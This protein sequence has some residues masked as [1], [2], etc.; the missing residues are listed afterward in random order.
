MT[1][2]SVETIEIL[3]D[4]IEI[5]NDRIEAYRLALKDLRE[6]DVMLSPLFLRMIEESDKNNRV[7]AREVDILGGEAEHGTSL[8]GKIYRAWMNVKTAFTGKTRHHILENCEVN[9]DASLDAYRTALQCEDL[10]DYLREIISDQLDEL[11]HSHDSIKKARDS[12]K[13]VRG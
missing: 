5:N 12:Y 3:N 4:L 1:T 8:E 13:T 11:L 9:E 10:S 7:L 6:E 2:I